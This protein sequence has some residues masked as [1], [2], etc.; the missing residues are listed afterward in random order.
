M[1]MTQAPY[2]YSCGRAARMREKKFLRHG[3]RCLPVSPGVRHV[4]Q[5]EVPGKNVIFV[6]VSCLGSHCSALA[7]GAD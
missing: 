1:Q 7:Q 6:W 2:G 4:P 5:T 3:R